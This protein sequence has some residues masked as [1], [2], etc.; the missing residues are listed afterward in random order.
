MPGTMA[1][2][3]NASCRLRGTIAA[4][5]FPYLQGIKIGTRIAVIISRKDYLCAIET[6]E[7]PSHT[8]LRYRYSPDVY[9]FMTNLVVYAMRYG[10]ITDRSD[11]N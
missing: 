4:T 1:P 2:V 8:Q 7:I 5:V 6:V 3:T 10:G 11:Y 9:K